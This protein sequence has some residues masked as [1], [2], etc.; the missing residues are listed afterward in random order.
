[1]KRI[2]FYKMVLLLVL[3]TSC[4]EQYALQTNTFED[5]LVVEATLTNELKKQEIKIT[6]TYRLEED[7][8]KFE[9][10]ANVYVTDDLGTQYDFVEDGER[11]L[12]VT[13]FE[14]VPGRTYRLNIVTAQGKTYHST[15]EALSTVNPMKEMVPTVMNVNG[16]RGV[17]IVVKSYDPAN[18]SKYYRYEYEETYKVIAPMWDDER[19]ITDGE[20]IGIIPRVGESKT[21]YGTQI[22][23]EIIQTTT[24]TFSE[25]RVN[26]PVRFISNKNYIITHRYSIFVRQYVQSLAAYTFYKTLKEISGNGGGSLLSQQQPGFFYGNMSADDNPVEKVLGFF[27]VASVSSD[28]IFFNYEDLFPGEPLPPYFRECDIRSF[29]FCFN[30]SDPDCKGAALLSVIGSNSLLYFDDSGLMYF[31]VPPDCGDCRLFSSNI[32]PL[33]W[34][35]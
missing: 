20:G 24:N 10:G 17:G 35:D 25:D 9:S 5:A 23:N 11:Y 12:S 32:R 15:G 18:S 1:M 33:F 6:H 30:F 13:D 14:A 28:R 27:E 22:S 26:F 3:M 2:F 21:C 7:G 8:P 19:A 16:E 31:M 4:T 34:I 29:K